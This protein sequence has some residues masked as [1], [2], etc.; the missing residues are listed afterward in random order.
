MGNMVGEKALDSLFREARSHTPWSRDRS[1][2]R[3]CGICTTS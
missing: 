2:I 1:L 3:R